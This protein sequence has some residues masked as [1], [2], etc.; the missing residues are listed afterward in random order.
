MTSVFRVTSYH[1]GRGVYSLCHNGRE[2]C[3]S[4]QP[5]FDGARK[6]LANGTDPETLIQCFAGGNHSPSFQ[7]TVG[8]LAALTVHEPDKGRIAIKRYVAN[9]IF[10]GAS[11]D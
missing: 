9:P 3:A 5:F 7:S 10:S 2:I 8:K 11:N 4:R 1:K 6:L